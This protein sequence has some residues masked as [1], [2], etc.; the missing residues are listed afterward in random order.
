MAL[1]SPSAA[2]GA[3]VRRVQNE[4]FDLGADLATPVVP[5]PAYPPLRVTQDYI[6][7]LEAD[8]D[9]FNADLSRADVVHPARRHRRPRPCCTRPERSRGAPNAARG[10]CATG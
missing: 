2:V 6:D 9:R 10:R 8:C 4:L 1:G 5:D 7:R 3:V